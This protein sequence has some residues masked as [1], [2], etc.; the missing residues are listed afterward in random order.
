MIV[1]VVM[2]I[3]TV[4]IVVMLVVMVAYLLEFWVL[5]RSG[6]TVSAIPNY[7]LLLEVI[8]LMVSRTML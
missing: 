1:I 7:L 3:I 5:F 4:I 8:W 2:I 6:V